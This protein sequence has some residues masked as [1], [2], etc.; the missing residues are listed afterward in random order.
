MYNE[1]YCCGIED[2]EV[3]SHITKGQK[4]AEPFVSAGWLLCLKRQYSAKNKPVGWAVST[5]RKITK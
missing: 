2:Q 1:Q 5:D 4:N 3:H